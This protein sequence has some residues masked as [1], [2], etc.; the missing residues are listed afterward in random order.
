MG[1]RDA[2]NRKGRDREGK[3]HPTME[4]LTKLVKKQKGR[5]QL[6]YSWDG[7]RPFEDTSGL[8]KA[9][10]DAPADKKAASYEALRTE[11]L[12]GDW[13]KTYIGKVRGC[14]SAAAAQQKPIKVIGITGGAITTLEQKELPNVLEQIKVELE[15]QD[16]KLNMRYYPDIVTYDDFVAEYLQ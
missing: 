6:V 14:I 5:V 2:A 11:V 8:Q 13:W 1:E 12:G 7:G 15:S 9:Y 16:L 10:M 4:S 3:E